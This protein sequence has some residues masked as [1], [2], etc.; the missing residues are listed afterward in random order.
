MADIEQQ[1]RQ[2]AQA[3]RAGRKDN[4]DFWIKL[5]EQLVHIRYFAVRGKKGE[6]LGVLETTQNIAPLKLIEGEKR[7]MS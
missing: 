7:L 4:E 5:G 6:Y 1:L 3:L 2:A